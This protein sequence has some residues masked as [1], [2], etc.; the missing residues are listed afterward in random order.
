MQCFA[1]AMV[2]YAIPL[3]SLSLTGLL[4]LSERVAALFIDYFGLGKTIE[5]VQWA[6]V[7]LTLSAIYLGSLKQPSEL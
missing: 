1:W 2:A 3:L 7:V 5:G 6:G 4:L